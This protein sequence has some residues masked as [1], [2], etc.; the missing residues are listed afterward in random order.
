MGN[1]I[2][3]LFRL[4]GVAVAFAFACLVA[5]LVQVALYG[6]MAPDQFASLSRHGIDFRL[7][8][9]IAGLASVFAHAAFVP[10]MALIVIGEIA[11]LRGLFTYLL[12]GVL[13][14]AIVLALGV[15]NHVGL[16]LLPRAVAAD[17]VCG[18][19]AGLVYWALVG[20]RAGSWLPSQKGRR[21]TAIETDE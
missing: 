17:L 5:A 8:V 9:G 11:R 16:S 12:G 4:V 18:L 7:I 6:A 2:L 10:A 14:A 15:E 13:L 1:F 19:A 20:H 21:D 3:L